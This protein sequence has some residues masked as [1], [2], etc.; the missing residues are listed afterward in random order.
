M[1]G[2][3]VLQHDAGARDQGAVRLEVALVALHELPHVAEGGPTLGAGGS[4]LDDFKH[5][6]LD[7]VLRELQIQQRILQG[8][9]HVVLLEQC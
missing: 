8:D 6:R 7:V 1:Q 9:R 2:L 3:A 4:R 5:V